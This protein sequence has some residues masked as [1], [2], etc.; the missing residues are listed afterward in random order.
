MTDA[1]RLLTHRTRETEA[2]QDMVQGTHRC[3][4]DGPRNYHSI[5]LHTYNVRCDEG[6]TIILGLQTPEPGV[7]TR[8]LFDVPARTVVN[9]VTHRARRQTNAPAYHGD[10]D[11]EQDRR[12]ARAP[13]GGTQPLLPHPAASVPPAARL[14]A[15]YRPGFRVGAARKYVGYQAITRTASGT[16]ECPPTHLAAVV[17]AAP[18]AGRSCARTPSACGVLHLRDLHLGDGDGEVRTSYESDWAED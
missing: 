12:K 6:P 13:G 9:P 16:A 2:A 4:G 3:T 11:R 5:C 8:A 14:D 10:P 1:S 7:C 18:P 17:A 15:A